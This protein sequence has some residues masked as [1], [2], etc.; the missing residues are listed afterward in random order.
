LNPELQFTY[1]SGERYMRYLNYWNENAREFT[2]DESDWRKDYHEFCREHIHPERL[3]RLL[4]SNQNYVQQHV[5]QEQLMMGLYWIA[6]DIQNTE[7]DLSFYDIFEKEELFDIWQV[8]NYKH[9]VCNG[10]CPWGKEIVQRT[11]IPLLENILDSANEAIQNDEMAATLRF[12]HDGNVMP[13]TGLLHLEGC[14]GE[15]TNSENFYRVWSDYKIVPMA[16]NVQ[17]IFYRKR[18]TDEIIVRIK[19]NVFRYVSIRQIFQS[20]L[21]EIIFIPALSDISNTNHNTWPYLFLFQQFS[22]NLIHS[23]FYFIP[24]GSSIKKHLSVMHINDIVSVFWRI[25]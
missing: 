5:N 11:F 19:V 16:A 10:T 15:E 14:Y 8:N 2:S 1:G 3:M 7:L 18:G 9:Y 12:G 22:Q 24:S 25:I 4:F 6:S 17:I 20:F 13:L 21:W 23:P